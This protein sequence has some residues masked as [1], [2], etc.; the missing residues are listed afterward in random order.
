[1][2]DPSKEGLMHSRIV[3]CSEMLTRKFGLTIITSIWT[4]S[5]IQWNDRI[6]HPCNL[7]GPSNLF[8][9]DDDCDQ[10]RTA[11]GASLLLR[12]HEGHSSNNKDSCSKSTLLFTISNSWPLV[13]GKGS[14]R[15]SINVLL[16]SVSE[17][18]AKYSGNP[19]KL[20]RRQ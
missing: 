17:L 4:V 11:N 7:I 6:S 15:S 10:F 1:M 20:L 14:F 2:T 16:I 5:L 12:H 19:L 13:F 18:C 3:N 9:A 8:Q